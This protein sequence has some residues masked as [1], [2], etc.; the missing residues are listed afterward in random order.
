MI[1]I[2]NEVHVKVLLIFNAIIADLTKMANSY[3]STTDLHSTRALPCSIMSLQG[4]SPH[5]WFGE[6]REWYS[7]FTLITLFNCLTVAWNYASIYCRGR[8]ERYWNRLMEHWAKRGVEWTGWLEWM[9]PLRLLWPLEHLR[10]QN[11]HRGWAGIV[12]HQ[13]F[14]NFW[15]RPYCWRL[16][17][18]LF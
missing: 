15:W 14:S 8:L 7:L 5:T 18:V 16:N 12:K 4:S 6:K 11:I 3:W 17:N 13:V 9:I 1:M 10:C 2:F